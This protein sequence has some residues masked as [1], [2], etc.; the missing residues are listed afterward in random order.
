M[1]ITQE[2]NNLFNFPNREICK[3]PIFKLGEFMRKINDMGFEVVRE[4]DNI[5]VV[6]KGFDAI[7]IMYADNFDVEEIE[8]GSGNILRANR[9][10]TTALTFENLEK[11]LNESKTLKSLM[12]MYGMFDHFY[13]RGDFEFINQILDNYIKTPNLGELKTA[14]LTTRMFKDHSVIKEKRI[15]LVAVYEKLYKE[16]S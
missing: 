15:E 6:Q 3:Y 2:Q 9:T 16:L 11:L 5:K 10:D 7:K 13:R 1:N 14:L 4:F 8:L 12:S